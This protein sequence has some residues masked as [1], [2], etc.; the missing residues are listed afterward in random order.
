M[1]DHPTLAELRR[2]IIAAAALLLAVSFGAVLIH[3]LVLR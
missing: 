2:N 3:H 1:Q